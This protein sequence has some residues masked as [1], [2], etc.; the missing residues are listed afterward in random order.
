MSPKDIEL[1]RTE[2]EKIKN[3]YNSLALANQ[4][5]VVVNIMAYLSRTYIVKLYPYAKWVT[6]D[7]ANIEAAI[8]RPKNKSSAAYYKDISKACKKVADD[9]DWQVSKIEAFRNLK[10]RN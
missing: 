2:Y 3:L 1:A 9:I 8:A 7:T 6:H 10:S 4:D 5:K